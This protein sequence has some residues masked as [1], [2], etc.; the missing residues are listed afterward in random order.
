METNVV[1]VNLWGMDV[2]YL[3]V[4]Y[5]PLRREFLKYSNSFIFVGIVYL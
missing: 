2:G 4:L 3:S 5:E 1:K